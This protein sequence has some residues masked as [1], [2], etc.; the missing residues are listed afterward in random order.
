[1]ELT[2]DVRPK[3]N[4]VTLLVLSGEI[5]TET[6]DYFKQKLSEIV[7]EGNNQLIMDFHEVSFLNG[8]GLAVLASTLKTLKKLKGSLKLINLSPAVQEFFELTRM[9]KVFEVFDSEETALRSFN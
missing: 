5:G 9:I 3:G 1:M 4:N 8:T 2:I 7:D 6:V